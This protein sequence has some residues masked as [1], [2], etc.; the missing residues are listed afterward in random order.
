MT[1]EKSITNRRNNKKNGKRKE[2]KKVF[3]ALVEK[4]T[5]LAA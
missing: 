2:K 1:W 3:V 5:I 4:M